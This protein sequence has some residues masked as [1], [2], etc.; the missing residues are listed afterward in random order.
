MTDWIL[1]H[2]I[3]ILGFGG[4]IIGGIFAFYSLFDSRSTALRRA[5]DETADQLIKNLQTSLDE[6]VKKREK[7]E[8][9]TQTLR[10]EFNHLKGRN[11][12]LEELFKGRNP[13]MDEVFKQAPEIFA[14]ARDNNTVSKA[15][16]AAI[17]KLTETIENFIKALPP[18]TPTIR[19]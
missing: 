15:N 1:Q 17:A 13:Q 14:I 18:L 4:Y 7:V 16:G 12:M 9:D 11:S 6:E 5:N 2:G 8:I 3:E 10:D 19:E